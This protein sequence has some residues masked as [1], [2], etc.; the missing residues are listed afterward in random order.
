MRL[1][2][3]GRLLHVCRQVWPR[4][5][6][7]IL[8]AFRHVSPARPAQLAAELD[9]RDDHL[10]KRVA[11]AT[12][13]LAPIRFA[14]DRAIEW[15]APEDRVQVLPLGAITGPSQRREAAPRRR[16]AYLGTVAPHKGLHVLVQALMGLSTRDWSLDIIGNAGVNP[17]YAARLLSLARNDERIRFLGAIPPSQHGR[18]WPSI[19]VLVLPSLWWEN[20]PLAVLE[21]LAAGIPVVASRTGGVPEIVPSGAGVLVSPGDVEELRTAL[22]EVLEGRLLNGALDPLPLKTANEGAVELSALYARAVAR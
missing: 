13:I 14:R 6:L 10:R 18:L 17:A 22:G 8:S 3:L 16:F 2:G 5:T 15:G 4:A 20:S 11:M 7:R 21:A 1:A 9:Q 12:A 19:D